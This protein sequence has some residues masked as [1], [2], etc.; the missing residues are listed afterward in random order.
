MDEA[1]LCI[2]SHG[3]AIG[4]S[5]SS[6]SCSVTQTLTPAKSDK[7]SNM[8]PHHTFYKFLMARTLVARLNASLILIRPTTAAPVLRLSVGAY[9]R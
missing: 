9:K 6:K 7:L 5:P 8:V 3:S 1:A 2:S 4:R